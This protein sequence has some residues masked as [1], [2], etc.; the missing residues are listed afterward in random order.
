MS[1][2]GRINTENDY[3]NLFEELERRYGPAIAQDLIDQ[4]MKIEEDQTQKPDYMGVKALSEALELMRL[5]VRNAINRLKALRH[6]KDLLPDGVLD[7]DE[8]RMEMRLEDLLTCYRVLM[9]GFYRSYRQAMAAYT[10]PVYKPRQKQEPER[11][12]A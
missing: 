8:K 12:A 5:D 3:Q 9:H 10:W 6:Q 4:I 11:M 7:L 1:K 2:I